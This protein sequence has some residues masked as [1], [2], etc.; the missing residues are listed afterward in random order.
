MPGSRRNRSPGLRT[1]SVG[2]G[3]SGDSGVVPSG[4]GPGAATARSRTVG[5]TDRVRSAAPSCSRMPASWSKGS[6]RPVRET[7]GGTDAGGPRPPR[8]PVERGDPPDSTASQPLPSKRSRERPGGRAGTRE[9]RLNGPIRNA[10]PSEHVSGGVTV[11][12]ER[13]RPA[14]ESWPD[15]HCSTCRLFLRGEKYCT[16]GVSSHFVKTGDNTGFQPVLTGVCVLCSQTPRRLE[17]YFGRN[18]AFESVPPV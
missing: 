5:S 9:P 7:H 11:D 13:T 18:A 16:I 14:G 17:F 12:A 1:A 4:P 3:G 10:V 6:N 8:R 2:D 15:V